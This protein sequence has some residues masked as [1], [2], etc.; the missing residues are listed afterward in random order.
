MT[1]QEDSVCENGT[2]T[3]APKPAVLAIER[4]R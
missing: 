4:E 2:D 1:R 3:A